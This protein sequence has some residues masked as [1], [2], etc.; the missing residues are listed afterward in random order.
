MSLYPPF[1]LF[2]SFPISVPISVL[3]LVS[4]SV[5]ISCAFPSDNLISL[6]Y[7]MPPFSANLFGLFYKKLISLAIALV[8]I[9]VVIIAKFLF[10]ALVM[11][12]SIHYGVFFFVYGKKSHQYSIAIPEMAKKSNNTRFHLR[13]SCTPVPIRYEFSLVLT[14]ETKKNHY[15]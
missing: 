9:N 8:S 7:S 4:I 5:P 13:K 6:S 15:R 3:I 1:F 10:E 14:S 11:N 12:I 2:V